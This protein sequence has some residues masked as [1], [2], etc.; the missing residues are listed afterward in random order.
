[1]CVAI[2]V[3]ESTRDYLIITLVQTNLKL[4]LSVIQSIEGV[5]SSGVFIVL[6]TME[7]R[8]GSELSV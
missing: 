2:I 8:S 3:T 4:I 6:K 7:I 5:R 1:M